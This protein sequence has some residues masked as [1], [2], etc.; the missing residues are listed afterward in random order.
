MEENELKALVSLI[1][2]DDAGIQQHVEDKILQLGELAIPMLEKEWEMSMDSDVQKRIEDLIHIVQ[3]RQLSA[4][5]LAWK[6]GEKQDLLE[7]L[8]LV[9]TYQ[10]PDLSF[11]DL[12]N[13]L[14]E[15]Y[16]DV[17][18]E[19]R[20]DMHPMD[21]IQAINNVL[22]N[23]KKLS[24]NTKNFHT[25]ANSMINIV[26][27]SK[28]GNPIS[29]C[30]IY[31]LVCQKLKIPVFG[32]NL[33]NMFILTYK[34]EGLQ[35]YINAFNRGVVFRKDDIDN[36]LENL[37]LKPRDIFYEPCSHADIIK[38]VLRNLMTAFE[39]TGDVDKLEEVENLLRL[40]IDP[41][42]LEI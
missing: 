2:D 36:Y 15:L 40:I 3:L 34:A 21:Q 16:Y 20:S 6:E 10:Y 42:D 24:S 12:K 22:F 23:K 13:R 26:L 1:A 5:L 32:V 19:L 33:P 35:F 11:A 9:A 37:N 29:L 18:L 4:R 39:K 25:P 14:D 8:W 30:S 41:E 38:R 28:R 7:G 17:W 27:D 31:I